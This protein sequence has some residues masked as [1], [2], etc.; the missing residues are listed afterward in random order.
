MVEKNLRGLFPAR[1]APALGASDGHLYS[2]VYDVSVALAINYFFFSLQLLE[3]FPVAGLFIRAV[4][5][6]LQRGKELFVLFFISM[7]HGVRHCA[8]EGTPP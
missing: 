8:G 4:T 2:Q 7:W 1:T 3:A 5:L 6:L